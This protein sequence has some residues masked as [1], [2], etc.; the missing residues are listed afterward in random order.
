VY[1]ILLGI[2]FCDVPHFVMGDV[3]RTVAFP[4]ADQFS[5]QGTLPRGHGS[6]WDEVVDVQRFQAL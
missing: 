4:F 5:F 1:A 2:P 6:A 3:S